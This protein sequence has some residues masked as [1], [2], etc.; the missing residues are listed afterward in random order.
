MIT[1]EAQARDHARHI[2]EAGLTAV[3]PKVLLRQ[4]LYWDGERLAYQGGSVNLRRFQ[5]VRIAALGKAAGGMAAQSERWGPFREALLVAPQPVEVEGYETIVGG[6]PLPDEGSLRA[7]ERLLHMAEATGPDDLLILLLSGGASALVEAPVVPLGDL[8][9]TTDLVQKSGA[10]IDDLNCIRKHLSH[11]KGGRLAARARG[12]VLTL[13]LSD[14][15]GDDVSVI[16]SGP[17]APDETTYRDAW[18]A[19]EAYHLL[20]SVPPSVRDH[21]QA[22]RDGQHAETPKPGDPCFERV[23]NVVLAGN[24]AAV[25]AAARAAASLGYQTYRGGR[26]L[27]GEA[28]E[29]GARL[30]QWARHA[31]AGTLNVTLPAAL[32][33]G[34]ETT[35]TVRGNGKGGRNQEVALAAVELLSGTRALLASMGTDGVDGPTDAAG[36]IVDG[37]TFARSRAVG[38]DFREALLDNDA[39]AFFEELN[40]LIR[41][42]PTGTNVMDLA[43]VLVGGRGP[44]PR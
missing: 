31:L 36:A 8:V 21:L 27:V 20:E 43:I 25:E 26:G 11:L 13:I 30:A 23:E 17:T 24:A 38:L 35:V 12:R 40:D 7:G 34:G 42:G 41:T 18:E 6:H 39:Y 22:G 2:L 44:H 5:N 3:L 4:A 14:V 19:L 29:E 10:P 16:A 15:P 1:W 9:R 33:V 32:I 37:V 28:R